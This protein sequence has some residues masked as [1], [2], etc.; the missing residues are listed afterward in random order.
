MLVL[1]LISLAIWLVLL[2]GRGGFWCADQWLSDPPSGAGPGRGAWPGVVAVVPAR[3]EADVI[4]RSLGSLLKQNYPGDLRIVLVDDHSD[5]GT[6][7]IAAALAGGAERLTVLQAQPLPAGWSGK[8]WAVNQG[9]AHARAVAPEACYLLLTDADIAHDSGSVRRL[10]AKAESERLDLVSLMALLE[11]RGFWGRLLIPAFVFFFQKLYPFRWVNDPGART[12]GAAGG[13]ILIRRETLDG[14]GGIERIRT[15]LIDDCTLGAAVKA[16]YNGRRGLIWLGLTRTVISLRPYPNLDDVWTMVAR[17]A[18]TQLRHSTLLLAGAVAGMVCTYLA[19]PLAVLG[20][21]IHG[22][23]RAAAVGLV[24]WF[25]IMV[26]YRPTLR[27]YGQ[28]VA[29]GA[30]LPLVGVLY[31]LMTVDSALRHWRGQGGMW[32]GRVQG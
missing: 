22:D 7:T 24:V 27:L 8:L 15:A 21:P 6:G 30:L 18:F 25:L 19:A 3:N 29:A 5:D 4:E 20:W 12:A 28:P 1:A 32:K 9:V 26:C 17:T 31:S 13:C 11:A 2:L 10:V 14:I 23:P 16:G